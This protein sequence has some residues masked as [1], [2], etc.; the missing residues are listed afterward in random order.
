MRILANELRKTALQRHA[1]ELSKATTEERQRILG[2]IEQDVRK[3][4]RCRLSR[5][6]PDSLLH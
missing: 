1:A 2:R 3:E 4:L 6:E 5:R